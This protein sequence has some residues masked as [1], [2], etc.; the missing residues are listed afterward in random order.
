[1]GLAAV[2]TKGLTPPPSK[3]CLCC[4]S[5]CPRPPPPSPPSPASLRLPQCWGEMLH[6]NDQ[7]VTCAVSA[8]PC[9]SVTLFQRY[10]VS[11]LPCFSVTLLGRSL[12]SAFNCFSVQLFQPSLVSAF[13]CFSVTLF[14]RYLV[15]VGV[16]TCTD[17]LCL[18]CSC[19]DVVSWSSYSCLTPPS[20]PPPPSTNPTLPMFRVFLVPVLTLSQVP[21]TIVSPSETI[22]RASFPRV[23]SS[24]LA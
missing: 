20:P 14:Q 8:F 15:S 4:S 13:P 5:L 22:L 2:T 11:A 6:G 18:P 21:R 12:V 23:S 19:V 17:V 7:S 16:Q 10:L 9:F 1:M 24:P 3:V